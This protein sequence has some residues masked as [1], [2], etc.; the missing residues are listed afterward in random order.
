VLDGGPTAAI[1][2]GASATFAN[3]TAIG[4]GATTAA[5]NEV[6]IGTATK[7]CR[8]SGITSAA[9]LAAHPTSFVDAAGRLATSNSRP[10]DISNLQSHVSTLQTQMRQAVEG[11]AIGIALGSSVRPDNQKFAL[12]VNWGTFRGENAVGLGGPA[13]REANVV[14]NGG[15]GA[16][17]AHGGVGGRAGMTV[18]W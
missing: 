10:T 17:F 9:S 3:S 5:V 7:T 8:M 6:S 14:F 4:T 11:T 16:G 1:G 18:A 15:L 12:A 13:P 2:P